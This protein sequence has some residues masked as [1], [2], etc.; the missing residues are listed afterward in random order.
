MRVDSEHSP[1]VLLNGRVVTER[2]LEDGDR[3]LFGRAALFVAAA[4]VGP[5]LLQRRAALLLLPPRAVDAYSV[6]N[7]EVTLT[8]ADTRP[9]SSYPTNVLWIDSKAKLDAL[10]ASVAH[11]ADAGGWRLVGGGLE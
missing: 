1:R 7:C 11:C 5:A 2:T 4:L 3:L 10:E 8:S 9:D 6:S